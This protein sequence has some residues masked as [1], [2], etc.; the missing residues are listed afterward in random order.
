MGA[1]TREKI[2]SE[3]HLMEKKAKRG[4][5]AIE[6]EYFRFYH[7]FVSPHYED[8]ES[9]NPEP[10]IQD[11]LRNFNTYLGKTFEK[12]ARE[13]LI[14]LNKHG[15]LPFKFTKIGKWWHKN[16]EIDLV[17]L[18]KGENKVLLVEV[19]WKALSE[20]EARGV[21]RDLERKS[22]LVGSENWQKYCGLIAK[23]IKGKE[24]LK[25]EGWLLWD[26]EDFKILNF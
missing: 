24:A 13:F 10:A 12:V 7:R 17:A 20:K 19:K 21:L 16:E 3:L 18:D 1:V 5:Y 14:E 9:L 11:F 22:E 6:D 26:R 4:I 2:I 15:R 25:S 8:V 23:G